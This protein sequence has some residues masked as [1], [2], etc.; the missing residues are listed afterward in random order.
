AT[1]GHVT[2]PNKDPRLVYTN[3]RFVFDYKM[4][5][6]DTIDLVVNNNVVFHAVDIIAR[7]LTKDWALLRLDRST[8]RPPLTLRDSGKVPDNQ[9]VSV[10]GHGA[11]LPMKYAADANVWA[12][13]S[14]DFFKANLDAF[15]GNSGSPV[16]NAINYEVEGV[17]IEG[18]QDYELVSG[19]LKAYRCPTYRCDGETCCRVTL[20]S[21]QVPPPVVP[22]PQ[23][24][25]VD[26]DEN[27][28]NCPWCAIFI[29]LLTTLTTMITLVTALISG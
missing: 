8:G 1:A 21:D 26:E 5:P 3:L 29:M 10:L 12:N 17:V 16:F 18:H 28:S 20:F 7:D 24:E 4:K 9:Q 14:P 2:D 11:R 22:P 15:G 6:D 25:P 13:V 19:C 23:Q 27:D